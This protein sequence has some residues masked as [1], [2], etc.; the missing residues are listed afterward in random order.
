MEDVEIPFSLH[1]NT[2][3]HDPN[4]PDKEVFQA[5]AISLVRD[6]VIAAD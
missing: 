6:D 3:T 2:D 1:M 5:Y 4:T